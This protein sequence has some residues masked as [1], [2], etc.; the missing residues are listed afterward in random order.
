MR[1][2]SPSEASCLTLL[3]VVKQRDHRRRGYL[4]SIGMAMENGRSV[5]DDNDILALAL[6]RAFQVHASVE[7]S[8]AYEMACNVATNGLSPAIIPGKNPTELIKH[9]DAGTKVLGTVM[10]FV[11]PSGTHFMR[12]AIVEAELA[13]G[14]ADQ[15][16]HREDARLLSLV[17]VSVAGIVA[18]IRER[19]DGAGIVLT[20]SFWG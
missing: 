20:P 12:W 13:F 17:A 18:E 5:F 1:T 2:Y 19:A 7:V 16:A 6:A 8:A 9:K 10:R 3:D 15:I 14:L 4:Q 11:H